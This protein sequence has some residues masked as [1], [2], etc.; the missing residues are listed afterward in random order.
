MQKHWQFINIFGGLWS[1]FG[2]FAFI[3]GFP[4]LLLFFKW[5]RKVFPAFRNILAGKP[6]SFLHVSEKGLVY[7]NW[8]WFEMR[9]Q[10][11][12][13]NRINQGRWLGD[14]LY[15][16]R[17]KQIGFPEFS[18]ILNSPQIY[19]SNLVGWKDGQLKGELRKHAP[20]LF[21]N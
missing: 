4:Y 2:V 1:W 3:I 20:Q 21:M 13:V 19:L 11:Q 16:H 5:M 17:A 8:P 14:A 15:L 12:D 7:R 18:I 10:W 9:C 6:R